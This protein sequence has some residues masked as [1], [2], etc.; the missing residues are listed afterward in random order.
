M[1]GK[2]LDVVVLAGGPS[3]EHE[4]SLKTAKMVA[5]KLNPE[6]YK[7]RI[8]VVS[9]TGEWPED[10][11]ETRPDVVF[12]AMHG[13]YGEDGIVQKFL[14]DCGIPYTGSGVEASRLGMDKH[15]SLFLFKKNDLL[16]PDFAI[17]LGNRSLNVDKE[18]PDFGFP[19]VVKPAGG[20]SS[21]GVTIVEKKEQLPA[22]FKEAFQFSDAAMIQEY[23]RGR[24]VTCGV[25]DDG[26]ENAIALQPT[27]IIPLQRTFFDFHSKYTPG[28]SQEIT[29]PDL[30]AETIRAIQEIALKAHKILGCS[31][32]SRTDMI[33][34][35]TSD[36]RHAPSRIYVLEINTI[37][38]MTETSL[39]PQAAQAVGISFPELLDRIIQAALNRRKRETPAR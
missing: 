24:E 10:I 35:E 29:P 37:P 23:I 13:K 12:I 26:C 20:G 28:A 27:E 22:A 21:F 15:R 16:V 1:N 25:L 14:E 34:E 39:L 30:P 9:E 38:G 2:R 17:V 31:G 8:V 6:K 7:A 4:V 32:M 19:V 3:F 18:L 36:T 11:R 5:E 33:L